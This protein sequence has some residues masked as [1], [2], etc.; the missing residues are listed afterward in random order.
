MRQRDGGGADGDVVAVA[1]DVA[2]ERLIEFQGVDRQQLEVAERRVARA[3]IVDRQAHAQVAQRLE[4]ADAG[5]RVVHGN[6]FGDFELQ[7][8]AFQTM[9]FQCPRDMRQQDGRVQLMGGQVHGHAE[10]GDA[11]IAPCAELA[12]GFIQYPFAQRQDQAGFLGDGDEFGWR[13]QAHARVAPAYQRLEP[14]DA[15]APAVELGLVMQFE[16]LVFHGHPQVMVHGQPLHGGL[17]HLGREELDIV[18]P[19]RFGVIHGGVGVLHQRFAV[20]PVVRVERE[21]DAWR[22][23]QRIFSD[24]IGLG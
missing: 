24:P 17:V 7:V 19:Q 14:D 15:A 22:R 12:A 10:V 3:E 20:L 4:L 8:G 5:G 18:A 1:F 2:Y 21:A 13:H 23:M 16:L 9:L 11:D 6:R